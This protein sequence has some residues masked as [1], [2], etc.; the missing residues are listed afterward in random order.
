MFYTINTYEGT[1][2][3]CFYKDIRVPM[4]GMLGNLKIVWY[5][6]LPADKCLDPN[7]L[8]SAAQPW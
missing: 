8:L 7:N 3:M 2:K 4:E 6:E 1:G 5:V